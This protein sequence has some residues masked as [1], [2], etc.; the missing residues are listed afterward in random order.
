[1][2]PVAFLPICLPPVVPLSLLPREIRRRSATLLN[3]VLVAPRLRLFLA[4]L[5]IL[6]LRRRNSYLTIPL[7]VPGWRCGRI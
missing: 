2:L 3:G 5:P 6:W 4:F 7:P 1:M